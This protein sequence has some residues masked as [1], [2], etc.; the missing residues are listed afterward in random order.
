MFWFLDFGN[1]LSGSESSP[2]VELNHLRKA[3]AIYGLDP[4]ENYMDI[5]FAKVDVNFNTEKWRRPLYLT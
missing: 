4:I 1:G 5:F 3:K 2:F